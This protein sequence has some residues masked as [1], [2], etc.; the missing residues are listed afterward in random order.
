MKTFI[1]NDASITGKELKLCDL[2]L[3]CPI[4]GKSFRNIENI[5]VP[6]NPNKNDN[7]SR[8]FAVLE[9]NTRDICDCMANMF[10]E[11]YRETGQPP[12]VSLSFGGN[13]EN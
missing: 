9:I 2:K 6:L 5:V 3:F 1:P 10:I 7:S 11:Y 13:R 12:I 8:L 4:C